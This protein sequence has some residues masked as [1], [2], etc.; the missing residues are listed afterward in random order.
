MYSCLNY[1][2]VFSS[3]Y[4]VLFLSSLIYYGVSVCGGE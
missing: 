4:D 1:F 3:Y 2:T